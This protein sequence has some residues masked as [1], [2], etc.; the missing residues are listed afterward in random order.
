MNKII[1]KKIKMKINVSKNV[2]VVANVAS[3]FL[4]DNEEHILGFAAADCFGVLVSVLFC[5]SDE[6]LSHFYHHILR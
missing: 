4:L 1:T 6:R 5:E 3:W 2:L